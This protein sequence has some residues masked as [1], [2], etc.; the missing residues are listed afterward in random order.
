MSDSIAGF[1]ALLELKH[2]D[3]YT[4]ARNDNSIRKTDAYEAT[5]VSGEQGRRPAPL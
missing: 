3:F 1:H 2:G 4:S 5:L